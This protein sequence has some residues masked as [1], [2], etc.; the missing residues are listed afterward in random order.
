LLLKKREADVPKL[1]E[2]QLPNALRY[3]PLQVGGI[4]VAASVLGR[5]AGKIE[6]DGADLVTAVGL[7][8]RKTRAASMTASSVRIQDVEALA[9][10]PWSR[11]TDHRDEACADRQGA[12]FFVAPNAPTVRAPLD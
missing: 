4:I 2:E 10:V 3:L 12:A 1:R 8:R 6:G 9:T 5:D 11:Q 7:A